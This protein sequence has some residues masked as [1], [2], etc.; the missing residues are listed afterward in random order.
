MMTDRNDDDENLEEDGCTFEFADETEGGAESSGAVYRVYDGEDFGQYM[1]DDDDSPHVML[2]ES[3]LDGGSGGGGGTHNSRRRKST[4][5]L[6]E[7]FGRLL[8]TVGGGG[9][10]GPGPGPGGRSKH[11]PSTAVAEGQSQNPG[12]RIQEVSFA[13]CKMGSALVDRRSTG[14]GHS[15]AGSDSGIDSRSGYS[16]ETESDLGPSR[17]AAAWWDMNT[18]SSRNQTPMSAS[19]LELRRNPPPSS[20][21]ASSSSSGKRV[22][23]KGP[24]LDA[25]GVNDD[26]IVRSQQ[27]QQQ[28]QKSSDTERASSEGVKRLSNPFRKIYKTLHRRKSTN[29]QEMSYSQDYEDIRL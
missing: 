27:Q 2:P 13:D 1:D 8:L 18:L 14:A 24:L 16:L 23:S 29:L 5:L 11:A 28:Y 3:Q 4:A 25:P 20:S 15:A 17:S 9:G 10:G 21:F 26:N 19:A 12:Y 7:T 6:R 22:L